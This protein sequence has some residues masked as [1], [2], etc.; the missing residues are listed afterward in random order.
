[1]NCA[2]CQRTAQMFENEID[3]MYEVS[4][5]RDSTIGGSL[6]SEKAEDIGGFAELA[7][8]L[9]RL[10]SSEKQVG[11][12][13][14]LHKCRIYPTVIVIFAICHI[15]FQIGTPLEEDLGSWGHHFVPTTIPDAI[16]QA[17]AGDEVLYHII[18]F[19]FCTHHLKNM[20]NLTNSDTSSKF[21]V[22]WRLHLTCWVNLKI[23]C[24]FMLNK[25]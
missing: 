1:M 24:F 6:C 21:M 5:G 14:F 3:N 18:L 11:Y 7:G 19:M 15:Y 25:I 9:H 13:C 8:C 4:N 12:C 10:K 2:R 20:T 16:L 23:H 17:S 22:I